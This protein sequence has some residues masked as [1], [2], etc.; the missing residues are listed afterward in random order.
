MQGISV[1][2]RDS[3][4]FGARVLNT[5]I[6]AGG[7]SRQAMYGKEFAASNGILQG[8]PLGV[9]LLNRLMN[10]WA[11][12]VKAGAVTATPKVGLR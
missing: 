12:S 11:R 1:T 6:C 3:G 7:W 2:Y 10:T 9:L 4:S 8:C 5:A